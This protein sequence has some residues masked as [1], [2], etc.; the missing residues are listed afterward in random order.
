M[1]YIE[2][3]PFTLIST[4]AIDEDYPTWTNE[5]SCVADNF[6]I[7]ESIIYKVK[8]DNSGNIPPL[9]P[10][11]FE[12]K[13]AT[14]STKAFDEFIES[15]TTGD[16]LTFTIRADGWVNA[17]FIGNTSANSIEIIQEDFTYS[18][19]LADVDIANWGDFFINPV[20]L[21]SD[22]II[23]LPYMISGEI[24]IK[25]TGVD[26]KIGVFVP[27]II[28]DVGTTNWGSKPSFSDYSKID[29]NEDGLTA[30]KAGRF[31]KRGSFRVQIPTIDVDKAFKRFIGRRGKL[32]VYIGDDYGSFECTII[33]GFVGDF[34]LVLEGVETSVYDIT[35]K[36]VV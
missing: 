25:L 19:D 7:Y 22:A 5:M 23:Y 3:A 4:N 21:I 27:G 29:T 17:I 34:D 33:Y 24:T 31:A 11:Y 26:S 12:K 13:G 32:T 18:R 35:L 14:N 36:G 28:R 10:L 16:D 15:Q 6:I 2:D 8:E 30:Y 1:T 20:Y 9:Y